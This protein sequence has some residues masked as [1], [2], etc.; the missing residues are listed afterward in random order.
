MANTKDTTNY[1]TE[2]S[3]KNE[4]IYPEI[5]PVEAQKPENLTDSP[6]PAFAPTAPGPDE[7]NPFVP[8]IVPFDAKKHETSKTHQFFKKHKYILTA[9][10]LSTTA[11]SITLCITLTCNKHFPKNCRNCNEVSYW[12][13]LKKSRNE[14]DISEKNWKKVNLTKFYDVNNGECRNYECSCEFGSPAMNICSENLQQYC[15]ICDDGH[16]LEGNICKKNVCV[17]ENGTPSC[18]K[19]VDHGGSSCSSCAATYVLTKPDELNRTYRVV[20]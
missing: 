19:G 12:R 9:I 14:F 15:Q 13:N 5:E 1:K 20:L 2:I 17:C 7:N 10:I 16:Y 11:I 4:N 18:V 3:R 8:Q 6:P